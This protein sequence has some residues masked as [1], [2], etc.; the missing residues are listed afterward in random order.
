[1]SKKK[2]QQ[3][4]AKAVGYE[5]DCTIRED[6]KPFY[7]S[8]REAWALADGG[9]FAPLKSSEDAF[10]LMVIIGIDVVVLYESVEA[11]HDEIDPVEEVFKSSRL[12]DKSAA[13]R[14]AITRAAAEL[15]KNMP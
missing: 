9:W 2:M 4:A 3:L 6:G 15:G 5:L 10:D 11:R 7:H 12:I 14:R 1:M 8:S 13:T